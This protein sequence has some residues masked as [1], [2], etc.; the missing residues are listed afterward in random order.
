MCKECGCS[1]HHHEHHHHDNEKPHTH[2]RPDGSVYTHTHD[3]GE[4]REIAVGSAI[5]AANDTAAQANRSWFRERNITVFNLISSPGAGKTT[6]LVETLKQL[7]EKNVSAAVIVGDQYGTLDA[8]RMKGSGFPVTQIETHS[9]CHLDAAR[10]QKVLTSAVPE[11]TELLF[12]E[13]VGNLVCPVAFD[14]G[15]TAKIALLSTPEGEEKPLKYPALFATAEK[16]L[17]TKCD[18]EAVLEW[19]YDLSINNI[20]QVN[21]EGSVMRLSAKTGEGIS[22]W[23]QFL[24][25]KIAETKQQ[26]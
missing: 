15:E 4:K 12:I 7:K 5:L 14:L 18:L 2:T 1:G 16:I 11:G 19:N 22:D 8:E 6:L 3:E 24:L 17:L 13:N 23:I 25:N 10:I 20:K 26:K 21:P 9:S